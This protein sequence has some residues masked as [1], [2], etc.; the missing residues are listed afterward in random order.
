MSLTA[1]SKVDT[2]GW[3]NLA[4]VEQVL[5]DDLQQIVSRE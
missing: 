4:A 2:P 3:P 5:W 1:I